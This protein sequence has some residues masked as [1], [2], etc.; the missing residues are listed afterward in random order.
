MVIS[1]CADMHIGRSPNGN[2]GCLSSPPPRRR[3]MIFL[4]QRGC[5]RSTPA[6]TAK[7]SSVRYLSA[8]LHQGLSKSVQRLP[9]CHLGSDPKK[10][11]SVQQYMLQRMVPGQAE[12]WPSQQM[13][14][15]GH[16]DKYPPQAWLLRWILWRQIISSH[17]TPLS[18]QIWASFQ[19]P[20]RL[21]LE[22][23]V[24]H[25]HKS[26]HHLPPTQQPEPPSW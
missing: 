18:P 2:R 13:V 25:L 7:I 23:L 1:L 9:H 4:W 5:L 21:I 26:H 14:L 3:N 17:K 6:H 20:D 11:W 15:C 22:Y 19:G 16:M 24:R 10:P 8:A 12:P